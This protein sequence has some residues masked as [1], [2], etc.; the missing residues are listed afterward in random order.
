MY[1][2]VYKKVLAE[3]V[4]RFSVEA[5]DVAKARKP[6]QFVVLRLDERGERFPLTIVD[7][8]KEAGTLDLIVQDAG[9]STHMLSNM[10]VGHEIRDVLGPLGNPTEIEN[11]G[12]VVCVGG[13]V[14]TAVLYPIA[15]AMNEAGNFVITLIGARTK[16]LLILEDEMR[17]CSDEL[18][19]TTDDGSYGIEGFGST[20]LQEML[21]EGRKID[22]VVAIGPVLMM[23]AVARVT[24]PFNVH[25]IVSLNPIMVDGT[26]MCG[27]CR[28]TVGDEVKF[29]CV[30]GPEFDG[31]L[32]DF[33]ELMKRQSFYK[34][35]EVCRLEEC[36]KEEE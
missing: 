23:R 8:D 20:V 1:K 18:I 21:E 36:L 9:Y 22:R 10:E 25:T 27:G 35:E 34:E 17:E 33:E 16:E 13:G 14:G 6:G 24:E 12:T 2:I 31:H 15:K 11:F 29:A 30:D 4:T 26:G 5:P 28:V 3:R 7:S 19:V 32:V